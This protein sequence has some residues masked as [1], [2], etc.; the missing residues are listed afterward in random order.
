ME[1][2]ELMSFSLASCY[3]L[4]MLANLVPI[5][6]LTAPATAKAAQTLIDLGL[7]TTHPD[8]HLDL[9]RKGPA[10]GLNCFRWGSAQREARYSLH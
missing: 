4:S 10:L 1:K 2:D 8:K 5:G 7:V 9:T 3:I 6:D